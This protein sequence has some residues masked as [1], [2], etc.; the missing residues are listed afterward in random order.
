MVGLDPGT[1]ARRRY[2]PATRA[3]QRVPAPERLSSGV[4]GS[5]TEAVARRASLGSLEQP[6]A[7][8]RRCSVERYEVDGVRLLHRIGPA[9]G[10]DAATD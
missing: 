6:G 4:R 8:L 9:A 3:Q 2:Q 1:T 5:T 10:I 7:V